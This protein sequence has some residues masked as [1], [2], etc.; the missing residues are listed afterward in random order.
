MK[1]SRL[2]RLLALVLAA[3]M[4][5]GLNLGSA[6]AVEAGSTPVTF[7]ELDPSQASAS[8][9]NTQG[10]TVQLE[11]DAPFE[12]TDVVRAMIVL[13]QDSTLTAMQAS[14]ETL[15][16]SAAVQYRQKL[17]NAQE[18]MASRI[19]RQCLAGEALDVVWNLT[20]SA[21]AISAN[22]AYGKLEE[23]RQVPG[24]KA[25][26]LETQYEPMTQ[27]ETSNL[28]AQQM[29]GAAG[30]QQDA[31]YT[32]A[33]ARIAVV[34]T[35][36][37]TDHQSFSGTAWEY[38]L[39]LHAEQKG[40]SLE[41]YMASLDLM[42]TQE[43][44]GVLSQLHVAKRYENLTAEDL[45][46]NGKLPFAFNYIDGDLDITHD[47]D[48]QGEHGSH[49]AGI[50]TA[51]DY[52]PTKDVSVYDFD[53][54]GDLDQDDAQAL[55]DHAVKGTEISNAKYA[56]LSG[57]GSV[58]AYDAHLL[59][60][61][62]EGYEKDGVVYISAA[63]S[64][65]VTGVA[66]DA[67]LITMKVFGKKGGAYASDY[68]AAVEDA[69]VLGCDSVNLSLGA[70]YP[71]FV[72]AHEEAAEGSAFV[73]RIM[74]EL[75]ETGIVMCVAAG[76]AGNWADMDEAFGLM[77]PDEAG[78][79]MV[80]SPATY[81]NALSVASVDN[82]GFIAEYESLFASAAGDTFEPAIEVTPD[83]VEREWKSLDE[84][85]EGTTY[86]VVFLGDP[87]NLFA[88]KTQ[89]DERIY[90]GSVEDF[91]GF[92][93]T[94]KVVLSARGNTVLFADKHQNAQAAGAAATLIYNNVSGALSASIQGSEAT[95]PCGGLSMED[96]KAIFALC[97]KNEAGLYTCTLQVTSGLHVNNGEDVKYPTMSDFS[98]WGTTGDITIKPEITAP[99]GNI[100]SVNGA[101]K[102]T[103][104]YEIMSG[105][106]MATP[107]VAGLVALAEQYVREADL[108]SKAQAVTGNEKLSQRNLIQ[109]LLMSTA[110]PL[111]EESS[112]CEYSV[113]NQGAGLANVQNLVN[114][115]SMILVDGQP[116]GKVKAELGDGETGWSFSFQL[117]NLSS[118]D[119]TFSLDASMLTTDTVTAEKDG[120]SFNLTADQMTA[121]G[122]EVT[123]TG[124]T[125]ENGKVTVPAGGAAQVTVEIQIPA[126]TAEH[127]KALG[128]TNGFYVEGF[129]Y[130]RPEADAEGVLDV[131]HSIPLLGWYG[132]WTDPS[133]FDTGS[134]L[135]YAYGTLQRPSHID[136][137]VKNVMTWCPKGYGAGMYYTGNI[138]GSYDGTTL[139]G[140][141]HY[142]PE[143]NAFSTRPESQWQ[144]YALFPTLIRNATDV[145][146]R[147]TDADTGKLYYVNDYETFDDYMMASFYHTN[148]RQWVDTTGDYG[149]GFDWDYVDPETGK[150][151]PEG[152]RIRF[153]LLC[154][155][156]YYINDNDD[157]SVRWDDLGKGASLSFEFTVDN[158][159][160]KLTGSQ[161]L[162][163]SADG[164]TLYYTAQ[165]ENYIA[166][167]VLMN[168]SASKALDYSYPDMPLSQKGKAASGALDLT[169]YREANGNKAVVAVCDYAGNETRYV[170][171]L[172]GTG[173]SYG[174]LVAFQNS[175][176]GEGGAWAS[177][178]A[179]VDKNE[180]SLFASSQNIV[181]AEY[182]NGYI[183][184]QTDNGN[185]YGIPYAD[186][187]SDSVNLEST[188]IAHLDHVYQDLAYNY[189]RGELYGL[190]AEKYNNE[191]ESSIF[192]IN[193]KGSYF[194]EDVWAQVDAYEEEWAMGRTG[195]FGLTL[196]SD[197]EGSMYIMG[198]SIDD[199]TGEESNAQLWK[200][201]LTTSW[202]GTN[203]GPFRLVGETELR[204]N[205]LQSMTWDHN[206]ETLYWAQFYP[207]GVNT[208]EMTL[209]QVDPA[210]GA[211]TQVGTL[212]AE[213]CAMF[214]PLSAE[215]AAKEA[216]ANVPEMD[217]N[218]VGRPVLRDDT[219]VMSVGSTRS[220][221]YDLDPWYTSHKDVVWSTDDSKVATVDQNGTVTAVGEGSCN[222]TAAAKDDPTKL[223]SCTV[224][225]AALDLSLE[226]V[227]TAQT[228][229]IGSV[230]GVA[231][232]KYDMVKSQATFGTEKNI[233]WPEEFQG[234]GTAIA[235]ST[236]GRGSMWLCEYG[237]TGM[238]YEVDP[239]TGVVK[240]M[241]E[242]IDGDM[243]FGMTYSEKTDLFTGIMNFYVFVDQPF[244]EEAAQKILDSYDENEHM[245][246]WHRLDLS[247]YL[248]ESDRNFQTGET[249]NGSVG[250]VVFC[251]ITTLEGEGEQ[252]LAK[253][254]MGNWAS[255]INYTPT[256]TQVL[257]DNVGRL[258]Y[259]DEMTNMKKVTDEEG[260]TYFTD[261]TGTMRILEGFH[262]VFSVGYDNDGDGVDDTYSVFVIR[263]IQETPLLDMYLDGTMPR[264]SYHFSDIAFAGRLEDGT[265]MFVMSLYD[266]WNNGITNE[267][268]LYVPG[269]DTE[270]MDDNWQPIRTPDRLYDL[271]DTGKHNII[272]TLNRAEVT[273][274]V[275]VQTDA[276]APIVNSFYGFYEG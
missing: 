131:T 226:G 244:T 78:T 46:L 213:T 187:L 166:A 172:N 259:M 73:D 108:V 53:G 186:F 156:D 257:L 178:S 150:T 161:P 233:I 269:H 241:L 205:Y 225:V 230:T 101:L 16:S 219:V 1:H 144:F 212:S 196:A 170:I 126:K 154:A 8:L 132:N 102:E 152:T 87:S 111:M 149:V 258:W 223:D 128:Y 227:V 209:Q 275:S 138:Y 256:T 245:F 248:R 175:T 234:F 195:L 105:T 159:A 47:Y 121:L 114:A 64:V 70:P 222:I 79:H 251:G 123:Y 146:V 51:G 201:T 58:S 84:K 250:D 164:Q 74:E 35:G 229:G 18:Q 83:G 162:T 104:G 143:R 36:T 67:Q 61:Q 188:Y 220:L 11:D 44:A 206:T 6:Y 145:E 107:H 96:A 260:G 80:S 52:I 192:S 236:M 55:L 253:D 243:M 22:V 62:L 32:G 237:N 151:I 42:D 100:Y 129:V 197:D 193:L 276:D 97:Q 88:G 148:G 41:D 75:S 246:M 43:I 194:D 171:N 71:G 136:T 59:L 203:F 25:V 34:D 198:T 139:D 66:P 153:S 77:Y 116:D 122:A 183:F 134:Y 93:F 228:S 261:A 174:N 4:I 127:M 39:K 81:E 5:C 189:A 264:I 124:K 155:P 125:V 38:A 54:D 157:G 255:E 110:T 141:Q 106:S 14:G 274:G 216:H 137:M 85:G 33:G 45:Y 273:G 163:L 191:A 92:D 184:A 254:F 204:I 224:N 271:G 173:S 218:T 19:S 27:A 265:P 50:S 29:T 95:I 120:K 221:F 211:C 60:D 247:S 57:N 176:N 215:A 118:Q 115:Q 9:L 68:M 185:L 217:N 31:G 28:V 10:E 231:T 182:V 180:T 2:K 99:G 94:G 98:S 72:T 3:A 207:K 199:E 76:N 179:G 240:G 202:D 214:A 270:E 103:D 238:I 13:E 20:L 109:S 235:S 168:G 165:D 65:G 130:V 266:Y 242:P 112:G 69:V 91:A 40:M 169:G 48:E 117:Y 30:V 7:Q 56:D 190:V 167:V 90:A 15:T 252:Y 26:Y 208:I 147:I 262:G 63:Q 37:D 158:T 267:L 86:E 24:V 181:C 119:R 135:E 23:I 239:E 12:D 160:P 17:D 82:V 49:V 263:Q 272:A 268:Y 232:Y 89:T 210:T 249:G 133:M 140:D 200:S 142:Y 21:N 113:R 177:F